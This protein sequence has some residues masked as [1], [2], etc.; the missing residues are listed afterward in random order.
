MSV[1]RRIV[2]VASIM[3]VAT[4]LAI[5]AIHIGFSVLSEDRRHANGSID[6]ARFMSIARTG[7]WIGAEHAPAVIVV[8]SD[9]TC[10][11]S[12]QLHETLQELLDRYPEH[13]A[14]AVKQFTTSQR[15]PRFNINLA[16]ECAAESDQFDRYHNAV[17]TNAHMVDYSNGWLM[18][19]DSA[20]L[21]G[22]EEFVEC[23]RSMRFAARLADQYDEAGGLGVGAVPTSFVNGQRIVGAVHLAALDSLIVA[24]F[25]KRP[26]TRRR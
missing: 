25:P 26:A 4:V 15:G 7:H 20:G 14:V 1:L 5:A 22:K 18:L 19:A 23:V 12:R 6:I 9:Y 13:L 21:D 16:V 10:G 2:D 8:Y 24:A 17:F 3:L 11:F